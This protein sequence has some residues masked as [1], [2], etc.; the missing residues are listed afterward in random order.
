[1]NRISLLLR[2][3]AAAA[4]F[5]GVGLH[6]ADAQTTPPPLPLDTTAADHAV[7]ITKLNSTIQTYTPAL[8]PN[9]LTRFN[10][11]DKGWNPN[12]VALLGLL[13][14][15]GIAVRM[16][17]RFLQS[18]ATLKVEAGDTGIKGNGAA[19]IAKYSVDD[20]AITI[21][22]SF[23][24]P[25]GD[26]REN[27]S[28]TTLAQIAHEFWHA[29]KAQVVDRGYDP[30]TQTE[31]NGLKT[32]LKGQNVVECV[33]G[34]PKEGAKPVNFSSV[35][36]DDDDFADEYVAAILTDLFGRGSWLGGERTL[37]AQYG[38][39]ARVQGDLFVGY[40]NGKGTNYRVEAAAQP[41]LLMQLY[42]L[43]VTSIAPKA[44]PAISDGGSSKTSQKPRKKAKVA[45]S[46]TTT[47]ATTVTAPAPR[48]D[49]I[50][51]SA[52]A[53][54]IGLV[55]EHAIQAI[56]IEHPMPIPTMHFAPRCAR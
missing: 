4:I 11:A 55:S 2:A 28:V 3:A 18:G 20:K 38:Y 7:A 45:V 13:K 41:A 27:I 39:F 36:S 35:V 34:A 17:D 44:E 46:V 51:A 42:R 31:F 29:Y 24:Q 50:A 48:T 49:A 53:S 5:V 23:I 12:G 54:H 8:P 9:G 16:V 37:D 32:W 6:A 33:E 14:K 52:V 15:K 10:A 19:N 30:D 43:V 22:D 40:Q 47:A 56:R 25:N 26:L 21:R 1:M